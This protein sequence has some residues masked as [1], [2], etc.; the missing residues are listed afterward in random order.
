MFRFENGQ[1]LPVPASM[2]SDAASSATATLL[3]NHDMD[4]EHDMDIDFKDLTM[5]KLLDLTCYLQKQ[6]QATST[7]NQDAPASN[8]DS[9]I[10]DESNN[11][12]N[13]KVKHGPHGSYH[14]YNDKQWD[15]T[16]YDVINHF[17][18][19]S[20]TAAAK[21]NGIKG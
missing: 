9:K 19:M 20:V 21:K 11:P 3:G 8:S 5:S 13:M 1:N 16:M 12:L 14:D 10:E 15:D 6:Q 7:S 4:S 2:P 18:S 17:G